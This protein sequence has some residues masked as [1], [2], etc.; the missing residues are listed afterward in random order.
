MPAGGS[1][2]RRSA[3]AVSSGAVRV[4]QD[5][6][7]LWLWCAYGLFVTYGSLVPLEFH[8]RPLSEAWAAFQSIPFLDLGVDSRA[9]WIANGVLYAPLGALGALALGRGRANLGSSVVALALALALAV[10]VEFVQLFF[11]PRTVSQNDL[12]AEGLGSAAGVVAAHLLG[13]WVDR[14][15]R[16]IR[17]ELPRLVAAL[18]PA[19]ALAYLLYCFFPFDLLLSRQELAGK[20]ASHNWGWWFAR[21]EGF[22]FLRLLLQAAAEV[23]LTVPLGVMLAQRGR[24]SVAQAAIAGAVLGVVIEF[25]QLF[26]ASGYSQGLSVLTRALGVAAGAVAWPLWSVHGSE[27][28]RRWID[29]YAAMLALPWLALLCLASGW[30]RHAWGGLDRVGAAWAETRFQPFYYHYFT[31]EAIALTSLGNV[32]VMFAPLA[33]LA[34]ARRSTAG[35]AALLAACI[36]AIVETGKLFLQVTHPDPTNVLIA[37]AAVWLMV[38]ATRHVPQLARP[39]LREPRAAAEAAPVPARRSSPR[40]APTDS[41]QATRDVA[42]TSAWRHAWPLLALLPVGWAALQWPA[43]GWLLAAAVLAA[44]AITWQRPLAALLLVPLVLPVLDFAPW[45]GRFFVDEFD[46]LFLTCWA[47]AL[48]RSPRPASGRDS[49][50]PVLLFAAFGLSLAVSTLKGMGTG[51]SW[52]AN[53]LSHYYSPLNGLRIAKGALWAWLFARLYRRLVDGHEARAAWFS[54]GVAAGLALTVGLIVWERLAFVGNPFNFSA[55]Y[56]VTGPFSAMHKGGAYIEC[57]LAVAAAF[58]MAEA[59][60]SRRRWVTVGGAALLLATA[61]AMLVTYS[62]N[63]YAALAMVMLVVTV[64]GMRQLR[65]RAPALLSLGLM[66][67]LVVASAV[68]VLGGGFAQDRLRQTRQD[69]AIRLAHWQEAL[70]L[71]GDSLTSSLVGAGVGRFPELHFWNSHE[72]R[73]AGFRIEPGQRN[74]FLRLGSGAPIFVDQIVD[75]PRGQELQLTLN[76]RS[77]KGEPALVVALCRKWVLTSSECEQVEVKG[78]AVPGFWQTQDAKIPPLP[79]PTS[80]WEALAPIKLTLTSTDKNRTVDVDN[81]RLSIEKGPDLVVNGSFEAGMDRWFFATDLDPPWHI[82][83]LPVSLLF[84]QGWVGLLSGLALISAALMLGARA[85]WRGSTAATAALAGLAAFLVS[86]A[87]NTLIDAPRFLWLLLVLV[88]LCCF[89]GVRT[90]LPMPA[91]RLESRGAP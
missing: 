32:V 38:R 19:Y 13:P 67:L 12:I 91:V 35:A 84:D 53:V 61:Y 18:L 72:P 57:Y 49:E 82:H 90:P 23:V 22:S 42:T 10:V 70:S 64:F 58:V 79:A 31:S 5:H 29:R 25:G 40:A 2:P 77:Q 3:S 27:S 51:W 24:G 63:G 15:R 26:I 6:R 20:L 47:V 43:V 59:V 74:A 36:S 30:G 39:T 76:V 11:P 78:I 62:R 80:V 41:A 86:G 9:D 28:T 60:A 66:V 73:A 55:D 83:S 68:P 87:L 14:W 46:L 8:G 54:G 7:I 50:V 33:V 56:R 44:G 48:V 21:P 69:F 71:R 81:V 89:W 75:A 52:D 85:A 17:S 45:S 4:G 37:A 88:W 16:A 1:L 34:W 65:A